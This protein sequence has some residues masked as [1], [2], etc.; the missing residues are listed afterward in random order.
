M[1]FPSSLSKMKRCLIYYIFHFL[2]LL[3]RYTWWSKKL[4]RFCQQQ[5]K[6]KKK[7]QEL[8]FLPLQKY[9][10]EELK[11][12]SVQ[13]CLGKWYYKFAKGLLV[14]KIKTSITTVPLLF[15]VCATRWCFNRLKWHCHFPQE[16][17]EKDFNVCSMC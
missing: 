13:S 3:P 11:Y 7:K 9:R 1:M 14:S 4:S 6:K 16:L 15:L 12:N 10:T 17:F 8:M 2:M 5:L